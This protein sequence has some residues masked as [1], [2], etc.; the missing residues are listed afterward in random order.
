MIS[1]A[2]DADTR[3]ADEI[4][5]EVDEIPPAEGDNHGSCK[6]RGAEV[7]QQHAIMG[8]FGCDE[9][10]GGLNVSNDKKRSSH[11]LFRTV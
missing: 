5:E 3:P 11:R 6:T 1:L 10:L 8:H 4:G 7:N 9:L 2:H